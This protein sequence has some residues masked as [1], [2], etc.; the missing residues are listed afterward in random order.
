MILRVEDAPLA[1]C[2][3]RSVKSLD[4]PPVDK[5][6]EGH[7]GENNYLLFNEAQRWYWLSKQT[8]EEPTLFL[9]WD[10]DANHSLPCTL[11]LR[12]SIKIK[13]TDAT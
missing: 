9:T 2:D 4:F 10:S 6:H 7:L 12:F 11:F 3:R 13:V 5:I 1:L 8:C